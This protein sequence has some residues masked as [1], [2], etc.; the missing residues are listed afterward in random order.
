MRYYVAAPAF[1]NHLVFLGSILVF[2]DVIRGLP[3]PGWG[4]VFVAISIM[5]MALVHPQE[6]I[7][8]GVMTS[9]LAIYFLST[10]PWRHSESQ[11]TASLN[12]ARLKLGW[13]I[14]SVI[15]IGAVVLLCGSLM[16]RNPVGEAK[17]F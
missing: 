3:R 2:W 15:L 14:C 10:R 7:F 13:I 4:M 8:A 17:D 5:S 16:M 6:A 9:G 1:L 11:H 12:P